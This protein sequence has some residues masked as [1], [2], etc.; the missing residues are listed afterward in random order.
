MNISFYLILLVLGSYN[1]NYSCF[2]I[3]DIIRK[4]ELLIIKY[5]MY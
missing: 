3:F 4:I 5:N 2:D 1:V